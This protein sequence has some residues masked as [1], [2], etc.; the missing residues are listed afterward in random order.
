M[1]LL[2]TDSPVHYWANFSDQFTPPSTIDFGYK[3]ILTGSHSH[4]DINVR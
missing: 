3:C 1:F 2:G 4:C